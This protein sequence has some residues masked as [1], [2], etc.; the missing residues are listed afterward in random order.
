MKIDS[1]EKLIIKKMYLYIYDLY[2]RL[3][4]DELKKVKVI[5]SISNRR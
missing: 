1:K 5:Y 2:V 4:T 3:A